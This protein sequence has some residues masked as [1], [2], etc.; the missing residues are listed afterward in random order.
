MLHI[1]FYHPIRL[2]LYYVSI[3]TNKKSDVLKH[4]G[5]LTRHAPLP[6]PIMKLMLWLYQ[7]FEVRFCDRFRFT[8]DLQLR[9]N[10][11]DVRFCSLF[12]NKQLLRNLSICFTF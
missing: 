1:K 5:L 6:S 3:T 7:F 12:G 8:I 9:V 11:L 4:I 10:I 2:I